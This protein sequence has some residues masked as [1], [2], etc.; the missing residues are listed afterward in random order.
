MIPMGYQNNIF[1]KKPNWVLPQ[2]K[3]L[4]EGFTRIGAPLGSLPPQR[5]LLW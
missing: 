4:E 1:V 5:P 3:P 2:I